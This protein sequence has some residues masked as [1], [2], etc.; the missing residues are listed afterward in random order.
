MSPHPVIDYQVGALRDDFNF[1]SVILYSGK[2]FRDACDRMDQEY[3][4]A[5]LYD[6]RLKISQKFP[7]IHIQELLYTEVERDTRKTGE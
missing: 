1:G 7:L 5:G 3:S 4:F 2:A 6:L